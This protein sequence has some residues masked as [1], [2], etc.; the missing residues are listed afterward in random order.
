M[1]FEE[2]LQYERERTT[3]ETSDAET[4]HN[5]ALPVGGGILSLYMND[6]NGHNFPH[7]RSASWQREW[8]MAT[9]KLE[10]KLYNLPSSLRSA[11]HIGSQATASIPPLVFCR[12]T[13]RPLTFS[14]YRGLPYVI[15]PAMPCGEPLGV[16]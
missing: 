4:T 6:L 5:N 3:E 14:D 2:T 13:A 7:S 11:L 1:S 9:V 16:G 12:L 8:I 10:T 15:S